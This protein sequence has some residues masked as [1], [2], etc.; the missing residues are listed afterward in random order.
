MA[1]D[2]ELNLIISTK[3]DKS[4][5]IKDAEDLTKVSEKYAKK[6]ERFLSGQNKRLP[7][8]VIH[9]KDKDEYSSFHRFGKDVYK[10]VHIIKDG[11]ATL[12]SKGRTSWQ[13][14][15]KSFGI[16]VDAL[17][18]QLSIKKAKEEQQKYTLKLQKEQ[19]RL[20]N[21]Q[22]IEN[23]KALDEEFKARKKIEA[24]SIKSEL[25]NKKDN[26]KLLEDEEKYRMS[27]GQAKF[28]SLLLGGSTKI[29]QTR[30]AIASLKE[31]IKALGQAYSEAFAE[32]QDTSAIEA[33]ALDKQEQLNKQEK[34]LEKQ[35]KIG[36]L[37]KLWNT[38]K[39]IGI[40]RLIRGF[41]ATIK[42]AFAQGIQAL[43][44]FDK[45]AN[46][47]MSKLTSS[48]DK[49]KGSLA[50]MVLPLLEIAQPIIEEIAN[51]I[52]S[53]ANNISRASASMKGMTE[54][55]RI[56]SEYMKD[57]ANSAKSSLL[58]FDKFNALNGQD[59]PF[60]TA[61]MSDE[62]KK[63]A[64]ETADIIQ[65]IKDLA[66]AIWDLLRPILTLAFKI[67][68]ALLPALEPIIDL[69]AQI[70][71]WITPLVD[72]VVDFIKSNME[73]LGGA[74]EM[75]MAI[76]SLLN[77][78]LEGAL[79]RVCNGFASL[80]NGIVN[81]I[82]AL[83]NVVIEGTN[84]MFKP[85]TALIEKIGEWTGHDWDLS[86]PTIDWKMKWQPFANGGIPDKGSLFVAGEAGAE[87]VHSMPNGNTGVTNIS[88]FKQAMVEA[89]YEASD[90]FQQSDGSV[91][92]FLD[93]ALVARSK[94]FRQEAKRTGLFL[95]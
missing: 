29:Q 84:M 6:I 28:D 19:Q 37:Q 74:V 54:Y 66:N 43:A 33:E 7:K 63:K 47:T 48:F 1:K 16:D 75:I 87:L 9:N 88:Q 24:I 4:G 93:G 58:S 51:S 64:Q 65:S 20:L 8:N 31:E 46:E 42:N 13:S 89:L 61:E 91:A 76:I 69:I 30:I 39:R 12:Q 79:H 34:I 71:K 5:F 57:Y 18:A 32:G 95:L 60:E 85:I 36:P 22:Q 26:Q 2:N 25:R 73:W 92:L 56:N 55:T 62:E 52:A 49:I 35:T 94:R 78:D 53:V 15:G 68:D 10:V 40:Y 67:I 3:L 83:V 23:K 70:I 86:I 21:E 44:Q 81:G 11:K 80:V 38:F 14:A 82:I 50:L 77:G 45:S 59:S 90:V 17:E 72:A 41:F 27:L